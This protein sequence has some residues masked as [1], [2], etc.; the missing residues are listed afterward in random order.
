MRIP[1]HQTSVDLNVQREV[2]QHKT[3]NIQSTE[4]FTMTDEGLERVHSILDLKK[5]ETQI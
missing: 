2:T 3:T 4:L 5:K 1:I